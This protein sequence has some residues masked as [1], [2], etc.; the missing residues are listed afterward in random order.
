MIRRI[1]VILLIIG[2]ISSLSS[3]IHTTVVE[4]DHEIV[5]SNN[6]VKLVFPKAA[7]FDIQSMSLGGKNLITSLG[8]NSVPW[9]LTYKGPKGEN[10]V[11]LPSHGIYKGY[12]VKDDKSSKT[13]VFTW[14]MRLSYGPLY[15]INMSVT[16]PDHSELVYWGINANLPKGWVITNVQFP[17]IV[18]NSPENGKIITSAG[19]GNEYDMKLQTY[20]ENYPSHSGSM[21]LLLMHN[22]QGAFYYATEDKNACGK[23]LNAVCDEKMVTFTT[24]VV[25]SEGWTDSLNC[26]FNLPWKTVMGYTA[27]GW[28]RAALKWYRPFTF[29]TE[30]G[31]K[32][33]ISRNI[34]K[35]LSNK[36]LWIR[37]KGVNDTVMHAVNE[38]IKYYGKG[39]GVHWYYWH[40]Y[41]YDTHYP[42]YF[43]A[44]ED[45]SEMINEVHERGGQVIPY[46]NG[47]LWDPATPSYDKLNGASASCRKA[48]GTLYTEIYP[49]SKVLNTVTCPASPLWQKII[50][51]LTD[52]IQ[53][54]LRTDGVYI[55]QI[56]AAAPQPCWA[57]NH[58]HA[59]GGGDFWYMAYRKMIDTIRNGH[60]KKDNILISEE[61]SECYI[62]MFDLLLTVN[63]PHNDCRIVP[64][65]P[66]IYS[67]RVI[68][69]AFTYTPTDKLTKG[70]F[71]YENMQCFLYGSQLG[72]VDPTLLMKDE[73][74][75][76]AIFLKRLV[77]LRSKQ[78]ELFNAGRFVQEFIPGGDNPMKSIPTFGKQKVVHATEWMTPK[79]EKV[80][81]VVNIDDVAHRIL[82]PDNKY[83]EIDGLM[84]IRI[85]H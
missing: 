33:L 32:P 27:D 13:L 41:P 70:D 48:D 47:R 69:C 20:S 76:E 44:K 45:F 74:K 53:K 37:A 4:R 66:L 23:T 5:L 29:T 81:F 58:G 50:V 79:G 17:H 60:L 7:S 40:H 63:T 35:W 31:S 61:N 42:D 38:A 24:D 83:I 2:N 72:W 59:K 11:L 46:I 22:S 10:P 49:T 28:Q 30:W 43:P 51:G 8:F 85:G 3:Q 12:K 36:D 68:T 80:L 65:F 55:D 78:H 16:L 6:F 75:Q 82:L 56:A 34:P 84:G 64:L 57:E 62:D 73:S 39:V 26:D 14:E 18:L 1:F 77:E 67:D 9:A 19:W 15:P 71:R 54:E 52:K 21:Q 25:A